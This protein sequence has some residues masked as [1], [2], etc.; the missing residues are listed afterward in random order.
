MIALV[1]GSTG[2]CGK[3]LVRALRAQHVTVVRVSQ[4][5][6]GP[7]VERV[8][9][10]DPLAIGQVLERSRPDVAFHL[11]GVMSA[12][13]V[14]TFVRENTLPAA[15]LL[16]AAERLK[17]RDTTFLFTGTA[18][19]YGNVGAGDLPV[20]EST[21]AAPVTPYGISKWAQTELAL[22][23]ARRGRR[24]VVARPSNILGAGMPSYFALASFARQLAEIERGQRP[25]VLDTGNL[26]SVRDFIDVDDVIHAYL[27]L[28]RM[29]DAVGQVVNVSSGTGVRLSDAL[30]RLIQAFGVRVE[31]RRAASRL[32]AADLSSFY[33][34]REKLDALVGARSLLPLEESLRRLVEHARLS[35]HGDS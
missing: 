1:T 9:L 13:D 20:R 22:E 15:A 11:H 35:P 24:I 34:S 25:P 31:I 16:D 29:P 21:R 2:F 3:R 23:A 30:A 17:L 7:D 5:A 18:A 26:E 19:E 27:A 33:A 12:P 14:T 4:R 32:H 28:V 10:T 6:A 8:D